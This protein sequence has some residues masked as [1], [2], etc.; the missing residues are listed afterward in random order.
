MVGLSIGSIGDADEWYSRGMTT[1]PDAIT[2]KLFAGLETRSAERRSEYLFA[3][4]ETPTVAAVKARLALAPG[5]T[6][7][8][9][10]NGVHAGDDIAL[11]EG[12]EV[13]LFPPLGGG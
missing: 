1:V 7:I 11:R 4:A 13:S 9:L 6:G 8:V 2:V 3:A 10:V 5:V 12:D